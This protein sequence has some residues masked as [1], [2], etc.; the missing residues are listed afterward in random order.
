[1]QTELTAS[2]SKCIENTGKTIEFVARMCFLCATFYVM[3]TDG[4]WDFFTI[5]VDGEIANK[6]IHKNEM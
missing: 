1:M 5:L 6:I 3:L 2:Y 4:K